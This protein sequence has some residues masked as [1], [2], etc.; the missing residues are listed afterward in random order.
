MN[1]LGFRR[2]KTICAGVTLLMAAAACSAPPVEEATQPASVSTDAPAAEA[3]TEPP[4][5]Q[6]AEN[7]VINSDDPCALLTREQV[8][9][10]FNKTVAEMEP[11]E[12]SIG[13]ECEFK[14]DED[15]ELR[16][17]FY[18]GDHAVNYF[19]VL[20]AAGSQSCD[21]FFEALFDVAFAPLT[22]KYPSA[23]H[24]LL[25]TPLGALYTQY[26]DVLSQ[27]MYVHSE[28]R[29]DVGGNVIAV[30]S[31]FLN[32]GSTVAALGDDRVVEF[33]YKEPIPADASEA[34]KAGTDR[35][36]FYAI[37]EPYR[38]QVLIGYTEILIHL[39]KQTAGK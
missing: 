18:E 33:D 27:C 32:W 2:I 39:L 23:D 19:A 11:Q 37:A 25:T 1:A 13:K 20:I 29:P 12:A 8:E 16:V 9:A 24:T 3:P 30:E 31:V 17:T 38:D 35:E 21:E 34:L 15:T 22:E 6:P 14:F 36:K 7:I 28:E 5:P 4:T 26:L 10:G